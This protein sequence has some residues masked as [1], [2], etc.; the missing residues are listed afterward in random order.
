MKKNEGKKNTIQV[1][2]SGVGG[3]YLDDARASGALQG[4]EARVRQ[5]L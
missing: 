4:I 2:H 5:P 1:M 3:D